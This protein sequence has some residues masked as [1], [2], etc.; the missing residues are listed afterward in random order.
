MR[1]Q[2]RSDECIAAVRRAASDY[3]LSSMRGASSTAE[4]LRGQER[5]PRVLTVLLDVPVP[6][7]TGLHL[8][9]LVIL[10]LV[11][12]LGCD[13]EALV[14]TTADRPQ[15]SAEMLERCD[16]ARHAGP[17]VEYRQMSA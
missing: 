1:S 8:R 4:Q 15:V 11:R 9:Q 7:E 10:R 13:S 3:T 16:N 5:S 17:R 14:F 2:H 6:P 12:D